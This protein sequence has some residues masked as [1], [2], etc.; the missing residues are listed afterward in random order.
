MRPANG[1]LAVPS[2]V[3]E[4]IL[5]FLAIE[6]EF[7]AIA[8]FAQTCNRLRQFIYD[9]T[10]THLWHR[11]FLA[12]FDDPYLNPLYDNFQHPFNWGEETRRRI[13]AS[14]RLQPRAMDADP[15]TTVRT[16]RLRSGERL[17]S[18]QAAGSIDYTSHLQ[19][20][21]SL[22]DTAA[23]LPRRSAPSSEAV[24][25]PKESSFAP[26]MSLAEADA[27]SPLVPPRIEGQW[28]SHFSKNIAKLYS[29]TNLGLPFLLPCRFAHSRVDKAWLDSEESQALHKLIALLGIQSLLN[30][31]PSG[32]EDGYDWSWKVKHQF[33]WPRLKEQARRDFAKRLCQAR[34]FSMDYPSVRRCWGP[35][36]QVASPLIS[37]ASARASLDKSSY[38][39]EDDDDDY[40]LPPSTRRNVEPPSNSEI[41]ADWAQLSAI[42]VVVEGCLRSDVTFHD[43]F[44]PLADRHGLRPGFWGVAASEKPGLCSEGSSPTYERD[45]AGVEGTWQRCVV[46]LDYDDLIRQNHVE[47]GS[48]PSEPLEEAVL[49]VPQV[50][51]VVSYSPASVPGYEHLPT[52]HF[53]G[54]LGGALWDLEED[55]RRTHGTVSVIADG[56]IRWSSYSS[57]VGDPDEDEWSAEGIQL[58]GIGSRYGVIGMW[59]GATHEPQSEPIGA[60][61]QW[62]VA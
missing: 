34:V 61:W 21:L 53:E 15:D 54:Q 42:R 58:G 19:V 36:R 8:S 1:V 17:A 51:K 38:S 28:G 46:W 52:I 33:Q 49:I 31:H 23:P 55:T 3:V 32:L 50:L 26:I 44:A 9:P 37:D 24:T 41:Q 39:D 48:N 13:C 30:G 29:V 14:L 6:G 43:I 10:D 27:R 59:T 62:R 20:I 45:W 12:A 7:S 57:H 11:I 47:F 16:Y 18:I 56:S 5:V 2:E 4:D 25:D 22:V 60:W 35:F 40:Y